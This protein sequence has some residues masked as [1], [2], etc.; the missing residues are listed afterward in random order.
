MKSFLE[1]YLTPHGHIFYNRLYFSIYFSAISCRSQIVNHLCKTFTTIAAAEDAYKVNYEVNNDFGYLENIS[2]QPE[3]IDKIL[4]Q[5]M[6]RL[7][8][9]HLIAP[10]Y[11]VL[12]QKS[13]QE[14]KCVLKS[15]LVESDF[16]DLF[17]N[18]T[19][20]L[21]LREQLIAKLM[22]D[23]TDI[24]QVTMIDSTF[25]TMFR[26]WNRTSSGEI[27]DFVS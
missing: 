4:L 11:Q 17:D 22:K 20:S 27:F 8:A 25:K 10:V 6:S 26:K 1:L 14:R 16:L 21:K 9:E 18:T 5:P 12:Q 7:S 13:E 3:C 23:I 15:L 2:T 19:L 24:D